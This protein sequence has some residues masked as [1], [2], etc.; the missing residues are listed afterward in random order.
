MTATNVLENTAAT[1][2][3]T[4]WTLVDALSGD[5]DALRNR[6][7]EELV[8]T[9]WPP[10]YAFIRRRGI[11]RSDAAD[12]TQAFFTHKVFERHL[13]ERADASR[14]RLRSLLCKSVERFVVNERGRASERLARLAVPEDAV[15]LEERL[16][17][18]ADDE[19]VTAAFDRRWALSVLHETLRRVA[20]DLRAEGRDGHWRAFEDRCIN[21][22]TMG[23]APTPYETLA[24]MLGFK[25]QALVGAAVQMVKGRVNQTLRQ[26][27]AETVC[28]AEAGDVEG[29]VAD[30]IRLLGVSSRIA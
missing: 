7:M 20:S 16:L 10:I 13:F 21:P 18:E 14:G 25:T 8:R 4:S 26:V 29:E 22:S 19:D 6:A 30:V 2:D 9:Y 24:P 15:E 1:F 11:R 27:V 5:D 17:R 12:L 23:G 28:A 3:T